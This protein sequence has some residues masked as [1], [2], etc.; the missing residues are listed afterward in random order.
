[1]YIHPSCLSVS[2]S[3]YIYIYVCVCVRVCRLCGSS[4]LGAGPGWC[5]LMPPTAVAC[6]VAG[7]RGTP[8]S[9][10]LLGIHSHMHLGTVA[11]TPLAVPFVSVPQAG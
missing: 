3:L 8:R 5:L 9:H 7:T 11:P 2:L 10:Q 6:V 1:M 4:C